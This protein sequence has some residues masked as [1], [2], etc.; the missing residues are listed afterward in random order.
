M[1]KWLSRCLICTTI[2]IESLKQLQCWV[3]HPLKLVHSSLVMFIF[4]ET[5]SYKFCYDTIMSLKICIWRFVFRFL[6]AMSTDKN[7]SLFSEENIVYT[8]L[9]KYTIEIT[10]GSC[11]QAKVYF[12]MKYIVEKFTNH[13]LAY[14]PIVLVFLYTYYF[15]MICEEEEESRIKIFTVIQMYA[16]LPLK[17]T[18]QSDRSIP[19][20]SH[21]TLCIHIYFMHV[22]NWKVLVSLLVK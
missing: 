14:H 15:Y 12:Q 10:K 7:F 4:D 1:H 5:V 22:Y 3:C 9:L 16:V 11:N 17:V 8:L 20:K 19:K 13:K 21:C 18:R 6:C 2:G